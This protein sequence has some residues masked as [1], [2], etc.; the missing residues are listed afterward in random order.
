MGPM[1][2][3]SQN[4]IIHMG[5]ASGDENS[6]TFNS[7]TSI[8]QGLNWSEGPQMLR[9]VSHGASTGNSSRDAFVVGNKYVS[10]RTVVQNMKNCSPNSLK[11]NIGISGEDAPEVIPSVSTPSNHSV[12]ISSFP[13]LSNY[14]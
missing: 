9:A 10:N 8:Y 6:G 5:G 14:F 3:G 11:Y 12:L 7:L 1:A 4:D 2:A 13:C